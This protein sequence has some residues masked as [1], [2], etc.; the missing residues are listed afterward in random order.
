MHNTAD[1]TMHCPSSPS[2][3]RLPSS[4]TKAK[5]AAPLLALII[6]GL[7]ATDASAKPNLRPPRKGNEFRIGIGP[8]IDVYNYD[9]GHYYAGEVGPKSVAELLF[10]FKGTP[11]GPALGPYFHLRA[12][13]DHNLG[14][15]IGPMFAW[16]IPLLPRKNIALYIAPHGSVGWGFVHHFGH[17][18]GYDYDYDYYYDE[19][20]TTHYFN[21][22]VG[23]TGRLI[24]NQ[25]FE[26]WFR[27]L[28]VDMNF[29]P[30]GSVIFL[31]MMGG[32]G[33]NF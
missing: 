1:A 29:N 33:V 17:G 19:A 6:T 30:H 14:G 28:N 20:Y 8:S 13:G 21:T 10:H 22:Q 24:F 12:P 18:H 15:A 3:T 11:D 32:V 31:D 5:A 25:L 23:V 26:F 4:S 7:A 27:P 16:D 9:N 2:P